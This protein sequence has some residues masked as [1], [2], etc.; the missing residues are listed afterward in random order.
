M[1]GPDKI[2]LSVS[3]VTDCESRMHPILPANDMA[4]GCGADVCARGAIERVWVRFDDLSLWRFVLGVLTGRSGS[5]CW[6]DGWIGCISIWTSPSS[7]GRR[8]KID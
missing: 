5:E 2:G 7:I 8:R 3:G 6:M 1:V 4:L